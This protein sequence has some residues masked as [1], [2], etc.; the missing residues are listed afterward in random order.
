MKISK[1]YQKDVFCLEGDWSKN[2]IKQNSIMAALAFLKQNRDIDFIHRHCGTRENLEY[3]LKQWQLKR[4]SQY[5]ILYLAFHGKPNEILINK[6][7]INLDELADMMGTECYDRIIHFGSCQTLNTDTRHVKRF[8]RKTNALAV[9]G[10]EKELQFVE[11]SVFDILLI[12]MF[13]E[14]KDVRKVASNLRSDY[15]SLVRKLEFKLVH[16]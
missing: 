7:A 10:F 11:S 12:D 3:Y 9:C 13:Q 14:Y 5:S 4:Y 1:A 8:L 2:L 16:L 15:G 6:Q